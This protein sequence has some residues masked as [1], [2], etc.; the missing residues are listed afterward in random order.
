M[1]S[2]VTV[3]GISKTYGSIKALDNI[4]FSID[5]G[6]F[7]GLLGP[8]GA[9]KSTLINIMAGL[10]RA[11]AGNINVMGYDV[12][13][14]WR[15]ARITLGVVPQELAYDPFFTVREMLRLQSG[16]F[17]LNSSNYEWI[18]EILE[19]LDLSDKAKENIGNLSGGMKRRL[20]IAQALVHK[21]K[22]VVLDEPTA[23]VDVEMRRSLWK[24]FRALN[25][26]GH[27][28]ILTT[29]YLEEAETNC[30]RIGILHHGK[31]KA[32]EEKN[33]LLNRY[34]YRILNLRLKDNPDI[35]QIPENIREKIIS[36]EN[37]DIN[38]KLHKEKDKIGPIMDE[39]RNANIG[40]IDL[41]T[42]E[43]GLEEVFMALTGREND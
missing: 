9:G 22:V 20:L 42:K 7:F 21:P 14:K 17:G 27:T 40:F 10:T 31:L 12:R 32:I 3:S 8:N 19:H 35:S 37:G 30:E 25:R 13:A 6:S 23:G 15:E 38:L 26:K 4:S 11:T 5:Q 36:S 33:V 2:S 24:Y 16:Y 28:I 39:L 1:T 41:H 18:E 43:P 34:P 29:H